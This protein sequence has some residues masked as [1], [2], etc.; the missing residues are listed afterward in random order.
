MDGNY[1]E[2]I[3]LVVN[4]NPWQAETPGISDQWWY[5]QP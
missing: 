5:S 4:L 1:F 3:F 2:E